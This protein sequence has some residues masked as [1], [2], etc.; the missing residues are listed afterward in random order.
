MRMSDDEP[1]QVTAP[2]IGKPEALHARAIEDLRYI[3]ETMER[4]GSFTAVPG[5][6][7]VLMGVIALLAM[8]VALRAPGDTAWL[9]TWLTAA[10]LALATGGWAMA[11]KAA[12]VSESVFNGPGR[13]FGL[14]L[15]PPLVAGAL[16]TVAVDDQHVL[17]GL[18]LL[19]YGSGIIT[20]G[21]HSERIVPGMGLCFMILG[22][23]ALFSPAQ[24]GD[25]FM[26]LG[27]GG[28]HIFFGA[29]IAR[30]HGG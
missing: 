9:A 13:K 27:F 3:R 5:R 12:T 23:A 7:G 8:A 24:W 15:L 6:G 1:G 21:A 25:W 18:W 11:R 29:V 26:G 22:A 10:L 16:L 2:A 19:L 4:A 20:A 28:L 30:R 17:P 14:A